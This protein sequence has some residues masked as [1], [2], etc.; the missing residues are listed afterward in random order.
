[1]PS[2]AHY[3]DALLR[4]VRLLALD[5]IAFRPI[6]PPS[7]PIGYVCRRRAYPITTHL[8]TTHAV[9][10]ARRL[11]VWLLARACAT[12]PPPLERGKGAKSRGFRNGT[13]IYYILVDRDITVSNL[14]FYS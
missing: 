6:S 5:G 13:I 7:L 12:A 1:M 2:R 4:T 10:L 9:V 3:A 8:T 11:G 14:I